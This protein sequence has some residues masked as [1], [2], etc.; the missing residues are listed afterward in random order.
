MNYK[1]NNPELALC[2]DACKDALVEFEE[3]MREK[4]W[5]VTEVTDKLLSAIEILEEIQKNPSNT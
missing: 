3:L 2:L 4:E 5:Y 1:L